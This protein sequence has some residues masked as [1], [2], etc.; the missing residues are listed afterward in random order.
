MQWH[1]I[2]TVFLDMDGTLL[3][4][5]FDNYFW[6][7]YVPLAYA[8]KFN[9]D[10]EQAKAKLYPEFEQMMGHINWYCIDYW[11]QSL[12]LDILLLKQEV[13]HL[14]VLQPYVINFLKFL[15]QLQKRVVL[16]TNAHQKT[17]HLKMEKTALAGYFDAMVCSHAFKMPKEHPEFWSM[18]QTIEPFDKNKT[19]FFDDS[20]PVLLSAKNYG[21]RYLY[22]MSQPDTKLPKREINEFPSIRYFYELMP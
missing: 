10:L 21:I 4:L 20:L 8:K 6:Q 11:S 17:L 14:I 13:E 22:A 19:V 9:I 18:L 16:V 7:E 12:D 15:Q 3:D 2:N 5:H 1:T